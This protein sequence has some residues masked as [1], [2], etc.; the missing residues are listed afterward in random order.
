LASSSVSLAQ[1]EMNSQHSHHAFFELTVKEV[2]LLLLRPSLS[3]GLPNRMH[4]KDQR[5]TQRRLLVAVQR[6][7]AVGRALASMVVATVP[8]PEQNP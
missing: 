7:S 3:H 6:Q 1:I 5:S 4:I 8:V 2:L